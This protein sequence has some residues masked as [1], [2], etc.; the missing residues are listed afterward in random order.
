MRS[1][2]RP[3]PV[4][5]AD[6]AERAGV[7][8]ALVSIVFRGVPGASP[9]SR[10]R[11]MAA[12]DEL[13][14][15]P[16]ERARLLGSKRSRLVGVVFGLRHEFHAS[17]VDELYRAADA[18]PY[19]LALGAAC[20]SRSE[21]QAI[22]SLLD[23]RCEALVLLGPATTTRDLERLAQRVP[24][25]V[26]ARNVRSSALD[27]VRTDDVLGVRLAVE[28]L[29][30]LGHKAITLVDGGRAPG[31]AERR[32]GFRD[33]TVE[34]GLA[35]RT[36]MVPGGPTEEDGERAALAALEGA[37]P[38][39]VVA[40]NDRCAAGVVAT[41]R[42]RGV[43]V[44]GR[45]SVIGYDDSRIAALSTLRLTTVA[46]DA[47]TIAAAAFGLAVERAEEGRTSRA[48]VVVPPRLVVRST[49]GRP[50]G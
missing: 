47:A 12:A 35:D 5:M 10:E 23:Y 17:L 41:A 39:A 26:V 45:L 48:D 28:H 34:L 9:A 43:D 40:F 29:A 25:V 2:E 24:L 32:R 3:A 14:Y 13:G 8:R 4:T 1:D 15:R 11:V 22:R 44:P 33:T 36:L 19:D 38:T 31:A 42:A 16:D 7:S 20:P 49:T 27:T 37:D 46:Q 6:V 21:Q 30:A 50:P 18:S